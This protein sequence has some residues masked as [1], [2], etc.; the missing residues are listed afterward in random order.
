MLR[1]LVFAGINYESAGGANDFVGDYATL[2]EAV[3]AHAP[4]PAYQW[5]HVLDTETGDVTEVPGTQR[6]P[7]G[8]GGSSKIAS[9][10]ACDPMPGVY[11]EVVFKERKP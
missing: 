2:D 8:P 10:P 7:C 11:C 6:E 3:A 9:M 4:V 1:Y 5:A